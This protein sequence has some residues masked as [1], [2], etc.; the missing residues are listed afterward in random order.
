MVVAP[1][2]MF[3]LILA[4]A[5]SLGGLWASLDIHP[6]FMFAAVVLD[7]CLVFPEIRD[8]FADFLCRFYYPASS[9]KGMPMFSLAES[10]A[11]HGRYAEAEQCYRAIIRDYPTLVR[12]WIGLMKVS[13]HSHVGFEQA[14]E[15]YHEA[16]NVFKN[17]TSAVRVLDR[18]YRLLVSRNQP[19]ADTRKRIKRLYDRSQQAGSEKGGP[20]AGFL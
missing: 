13:V 8:G 6:G 20:P 1:F 18:N 11:A 5:A 2:K 12:P 10:H 4:V 3:R 7:C 15:V 19:V 9:G 16:L 17:K 14:S